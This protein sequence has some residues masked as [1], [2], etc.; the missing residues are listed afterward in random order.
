MWLRTRRDQFA[1]EGPK[2]TCG[3]TPYHAIATKIWD[4]EQQLPQ[5]HTGSTEYREARESELAF[6]AFGC[7]GKVPSNHHAAPNNERIIGKRGLR[8]QG[9]WHLSGAGI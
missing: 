8:P 2:T 6:A 7:H 9:E 4:G 3:C 1:P 5:T